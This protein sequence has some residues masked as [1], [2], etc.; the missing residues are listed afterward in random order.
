ME[1]TLDDNEINDFFSSATE[2]KKPVVEITTEKAV[3]DWGNDFEKPSADFI[4]EQTAK[5]TAANPIEKKAETIVEKISQKDAEAS[6]IVTI[7]VVDLI[8]RTVL[9]IIVNKKF[10]KKFSEEQMAII[11]RVEDMPDDKITEEE[12][13]LKRRFNKTFAKYE[14]TGKSIPF[15]QPEKDE[16]KE[17]LE[18]YYIA[19]G[20]KVS[21]NLLLAGAFIDKIGKRVATVMFE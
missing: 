7:G 9:N 1:N 11:D 10:E 8:Q 5:Q 16:M 2:Y 18:T 14:A 3:S 12:V 15:T 19:S 17:I 13:S 4:A 6:A 20:K 21:P